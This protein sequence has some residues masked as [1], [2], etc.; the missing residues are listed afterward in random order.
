MNDQQKHFQFNQ[1]NQME[2]IFMM[3]LNRMNQME[4]NLLS[5]MN[6]MMTKIDLISL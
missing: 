3:L 2:T 5:Q 1:S 4:T 6:L